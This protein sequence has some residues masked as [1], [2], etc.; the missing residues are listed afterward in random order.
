MSGPVWYYPGEPEDKNDPNKGTPSL[1][2]QIQ[3]PSDPPSA[4]DSGNFKGISFAGGQA[5]PE[6]IGQLIGG[7]F[8]GLG[9]NEDPFWGKTGLNF[10]TGYKGSKRIYGQNYY[11]PLDGKVCGRGS[12]GGCTGQ[13]AHLY[14]RSYPVG[15]AKANLSFAI[16]EDLLD[17]N[18]VTVLM[19]MFDTTTGIKCRRQVLPVGNSFD[20]ESG[21]AV[22][23][24]KG[25]F[26]N[27]R[28]ILGDATKSDADKTKAIKARLDAHY[29]ACKSVCDQKTTSPSSKRDNCYKDCTRV[30][31]EEDKCAVKQKG[32]SYVTVKY[33]VYMTTSVVFTIDQKNLLFYLP[34]GVIARAI[35]SDTLTPKK[36]ASLKHLLTVAGMAYPSDDTWGSTS[37]DGNQQSQPLKDGK[38]AWTIDHRATYVGAYDAAAQTYTLKVYNGTTYQA[39]ASKR[40][41]ATV[42]FAV[43]IGNRKVT[44]VIG[45]QTLTVE[46][47]TNADKSQVATFENERTLVPYDI[48]AVSLSK[49]EQKD[50]TADTSV[51]LR[52]T[53][54]GASSEDDGAGILP[55]SGRSL[56]AGRWWTVAAVAL[57]LALLVLLLLRRRYGAQ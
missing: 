23:G 55:S 27:V 15:V 42:S 24:K 35:F 9:K 48:P 10:A 52:E 47:A 3:C 36:A 11:L 46:F 44:R 5:F 57:G 37:G 29:K 18:P 53:F 12:K 25:A 21:A 40:A 28:D 6:A 56:A 50:N 13:P 19:S 43:N 31:W 34:S 45:G 2:K 41:G 22:S 20:L 26:I 4:A 33:P 30:W 38:E 54:R 14:V 49:K 17:I 51:T 7:N 16:V 1:I 8:T 32:L 39:D